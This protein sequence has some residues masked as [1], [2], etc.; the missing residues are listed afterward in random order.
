MIS[1]GASALRQTQ[2]AA[3]LARL[4]IGATGAASVRVYSTTLPDPIGTHSDVPM[5]T[6][7]L[8][9]PSGVVSPAGL[10][11][12]AGLPALVMTPGLPRWAELVAA[13]G[14]VLH[15]G[16]VTDVLGDGFWKAAGADTPPGETSPY[17]FAGGLLSLGAVVLT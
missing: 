15:V 7:V 8:A 4:D 6:H 12:A 14:V 17:F 16:D 3:T 2:L 13:D 11:L 1:F 10:T 9:R 5:C